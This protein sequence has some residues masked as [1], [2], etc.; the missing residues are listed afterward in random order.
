MDQFICVS[1]S[2]T[3]YWY[4]VGMLKVPASVQSVNESLNDKHEGSKHKTSLGINNSLVPSL[5][6]TWFWGM[7]VGG[8][9]RRV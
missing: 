9:S 1:L 3:H 4:E 7:R 2:H 8:S 6:E 5:S